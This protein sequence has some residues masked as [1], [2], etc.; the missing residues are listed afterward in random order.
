[1]KKFIQSHVFAIIFCI[2][3]FVPISAQSTDITPQKA[4]DLVNKAVQLIVQKGERAAFPILRNPRGGFNQG[5]LY[6]FVN[7]FSGKILVYPDRKMEGRNL[8]AAKDIRGNFYTANF[9]RIAKSRAGQGWTEY[10]WPKPG[11]R[12]PS[13]KATFVMR[14]PGTD[15]LVGAGVY[16]IKMKDAAKKTGF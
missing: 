12:R 6:I 13:I 9:V 1:M 14:I 2:L 5:E 3:F 15:R 16:D 11:E 8:I 10:W 4:V 7:D